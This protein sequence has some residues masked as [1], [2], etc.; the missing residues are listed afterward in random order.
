MTEKNS[1]FIKTVRS[2]LST[3]IMWTENWQLVRV[4]PDLCLVHCEVS[5][6]VNEKDFIGV[7]WSVNIRT[8]VEGLKDCR[9]GRVCKIKVNGQFWGFIR[10]FMKLRDKGTFLIVHLL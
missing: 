9:G 7:V 5:S 6:P 1:S 4:P 2:A 8:V 10:P 3:G